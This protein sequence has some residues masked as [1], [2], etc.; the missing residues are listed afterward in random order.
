MNI[1]ISFS[2]IVTYATLKLQHRETQRLQQH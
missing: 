2:P 1:A